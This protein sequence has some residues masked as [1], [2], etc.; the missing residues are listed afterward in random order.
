MLKEDIVIV[1]E[2]DEIIGYKERENLNKSDIYRISAL[3]IQ[4]SRGDILLA[5]RSFNRKKNPGKWGPAV[6]GT[7]GK[8]E[9]YS[10][11]ILKEAEEEIGLKNHHFQKSLYSFHKGERK[12]FTQWFFALIDRNIGDFRIQKEEVEKIKWF[13]KKELLRD[14]K[15]SPEKFLKIIPECLCFFKNQ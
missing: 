8:G 14:L 3:W 10:S 12:H 15:N 7:V 2:K 5:Q 11:N 4:N 1:N 9:S 6:A 13:T